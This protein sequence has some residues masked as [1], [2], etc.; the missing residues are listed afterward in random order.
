MRLTII[1]LIKMNYIMNSVSFH[2]WIYKYYLFLLT[3]C[4]KNILGKLKNECPFKGGFFFGTQNMY[5]FSP[6]FNK[7]FHICSYIA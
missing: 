6:N 3:G 2:S 7:T 5:Y 4:A 1:I